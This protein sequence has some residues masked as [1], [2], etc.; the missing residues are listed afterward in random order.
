MAQWS[1]AGLW[2]GEYAYDADAG[3]QSSQPVGF[4]LELKLGWFGRVFGSVYDDPICG[5]PEPGI[6]KGRVSGLTLRFVKEQSVCYVRKEDRLITLREFALREWKMALDN[7]PAPPPIWYQ[8]DYDL[9]TERVSGTW[10]IRP[11]VCRL[12]S[13][14]QYFEFPAPRVTG[15]WSMGKADGN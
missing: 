7:D 13:G 10:E 9:R 2:R 1:A 11:E 6:A 14:G 12:L 15:T 8:G 5:A 4:M 3:K